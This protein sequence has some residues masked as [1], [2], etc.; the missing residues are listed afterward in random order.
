VETCLL[1]N[2]GA[3]IALPK[4]RTS[5]SLRLVNSSFS[6]L[7]EARIDICQSSSPP[8][9]NSL[10]GS[11]ILSIFLVFFITNTPALFFR[12]RLK[13]YNER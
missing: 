7:F 4:Q 9:K 3:K 6:F 1:D 5:E 10:Q 13:G 8:E 12:L 2:R 11:W